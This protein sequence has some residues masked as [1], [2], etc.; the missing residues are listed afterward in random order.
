M[1]DEVQPIYW[2]EVPDDRF[3]LLK[4]IPHLLADVLY[5]DEGQEDERIE[6]GLAVLNFEQSLKQDVL[7]GVLRVWH[8][9]TSERFPIDRYMPLDKV[10]VMPIH[11]LAPWLKASNSLIG[12]R[13]APPPGLVYADKAQ[14]F[15][16]QQERKVDRIEANP[17]FSI[18]RTWWETAGPYV[19]DMLRKGRFATAKEL[20]VAMHADVDTDQ[21][22]FTKGEGPHRG[23]L[24]V[25]AIS[26]P[27]AL[28]TVQNKWG[29]L[30][31]A[32]VSAK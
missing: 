3:I 29:E 14:A 11:D 15:A 13:V 8:P 19:I 23:S 18:G 24:I 4:D 27:L 30:Q 26:K 6:Y 10:L 9:L 25:R 7:S 32:A 12:V 22:P 31:R 28:K 16:Q 17:T 2:L 1:T 5:P 21:S 20:Y